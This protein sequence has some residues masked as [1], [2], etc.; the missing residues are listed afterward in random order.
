MYANEMEIMICFVCKQ[1]QTESRTLYCHHSFCTLC[2]KLEFEQGS[3]LP[4]VY[5]PKCLKKCK[6]DKL[7]V[8]GLPRNMEVENLVQLYKQNQIQSHHPQQSSEYQTEYDNNYNYS[9]TNS[10]QYNDYST[11]GYQSQYHNNNNEVYNSYQDPNNYNYDNN[12]SYNNYNQPNEQQIPQ[13]I[14]YPN[15]E[16]ITVTSQNYQPET[17]ENYINNNNQVNNHSNNQTFNDTHNI[18]SDA[19]FYAS[20]NKPLPKLDFEDTTIYNNS[21]QYNDINNNNNNNNNQYND[22][23][24]TPGKSLLSKSSPLFLAKSASSPQF[25]PVP[26]A[27]DGNKVFF[28]YDFDNNPKAYSSSLSVSPSEHNHLTSSLTSFDQKIIN[29]IAENEPITYPML[30]QSLPLPHDHQQIIPDNNAILNDQNQPQNQNNNNN[31]DNKEEVGILTSLT[32]TLTS[33]LEYLKN[34]I[35]PEDDVTSTATGV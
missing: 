34:M 11:D 8:L 21:G 35:F 18:Y 5:C 15:L 28:T 16:E 10:Y 25:F 20:T 3:I 27:E 26:V 17:N 1:P 19:N 12:I 24:N 22:N 30:S 9:S 33:G 4:F 14:Y 13:N 29:N 23:N 2:L 6:L 7:G 32:S 31:N